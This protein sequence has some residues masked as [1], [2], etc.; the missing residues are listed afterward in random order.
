MK[1]PGKYI[2]WIESVLNICKSVIC[3]YCYSLKTC[4]S[5]ITLK[6]CGV[7]L[8][9]LPMSVWGS[10]RFSRVLDIRKN[11]SRWILR[12]WIRVW[13]S[14]LNRLS[15]LSC[16]PFC[17]VLLAWSPDLPQLWTEKKAIRYD[18]HN[19]NAGYASYWTG[20]WTGVHFIADKQLHINSTVQKSVFSLLQQFYSALY[21]IFE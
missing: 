8:H 11:T 20:Y 3:I 10:S 15:I 12:L 1:A 16:A 4:G 2:G 9:V 13:C 17:P 21:N 7:S 19:D 18:K 6:P 5:D 14:D